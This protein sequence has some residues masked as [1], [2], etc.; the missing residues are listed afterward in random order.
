MKDTS[1]LL[2]EFIDRY[3]DNLKRED[4]Q[5]IQRNMNKSI[6]KYA[7]SFNSVSEEML[8]SK[9]VDEHIKSTI[10]ESLELLETLKR[11]IRELDVITDSLTAEN[12]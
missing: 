9:Y 12:N 3:K 2:E 4:L 6:D 1:V 8:E 7:D 10:S 5:N 11:N